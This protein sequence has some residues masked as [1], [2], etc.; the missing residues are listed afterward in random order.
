MGKRGTRRRASV[1]AVLRVLIVVFALGVCTLTCSAASPVP[2][3]TASA[4]MRAAMSMDVTAT[5]IS[6]LS[7]D[8]AAH[9]GQRT[10]AAPASSVSGPCLCCAGSSGCHY[11]VAAG[12]VQPLAAGTHAQPNAP[13]F[14]DSSSTTEAGR[15]DP[16]PKSLS[17]L[18]LLRI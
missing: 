13:P 1:H 2:P 3:A 9:P 5:G 6:A 7:L 4:P 15:A 17:E 14:E 10:H 16:V 8:S 12:S 11:T 18:S